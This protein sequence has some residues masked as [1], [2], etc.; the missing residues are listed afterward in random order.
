MSQTPK[1]SVPICQHEW[2]PVLG[3]DGSKFKWR[4]CDKCGEVKFE[5]AT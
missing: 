3:P 2:K 1:K 4:K 5:R